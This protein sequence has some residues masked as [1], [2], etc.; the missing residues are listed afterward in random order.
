MGFW[1][2]LIYLVS[3]GLVAAFYLTALSMIFVFIHGVVE[4]IIGK[5]DSPYSHSLSVPLSGMV[6]I[7]LL[8][9][10]WPSRLFS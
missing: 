6:F 7:I 10:T 3:Y 5:D 2:F 1:G 8:Y 9:F 4:V